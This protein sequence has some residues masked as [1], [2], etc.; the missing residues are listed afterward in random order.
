MIHS[1]SSIKGLNKGA[2]SQP[3]VHQDQAQPVVISLSHQ[4]L[5]FPFTCGAPYQGLSAN[6]A[7]ETFNLEN[8]VFTATTTHKSQY[9]D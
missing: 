5:S 1:E 3:V 9:S 6:E 4:Q 7:P 8:L 2:D